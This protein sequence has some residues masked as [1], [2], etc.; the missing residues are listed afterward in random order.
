MRLVILDSN[1]D[2]STWTAKYI[3]K[4]IHQFNPGPDRY[5]TLGLPTGST[6]L[7]TYNKLIEF[8]RDGTLSFHYVK[9]FNMDEYVGLPRDHP[10]SYHSFMWNSLFKHVDIQQENTHIL[11]GNA[12]NLQKECE[13][14]EKKISEAGGIELFVGGIGPDGHIAFNEPGSSLASRTRVKTLAMDTILANARFFDND[15]SKVPRQALTV[16]VGTVM[17][18]RE[19]LVIISGAHKSFALYKAV[20]EGVSHMWTISAFQLHRQAIFV[21]DEDATLELRVKTVKYFKGLMKIHNK[22]I[23]ED[24]EPEE[25]K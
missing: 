6:P 20:E 18:A 13:E 21:C 15:L 22:L 7:G 1:D 19:V 8:Y 25:G 3:R 10:Q 11:N 17:D 14:F 5:F 16:G 9:T 12:P 4:R 23:Q 24:N 2:V